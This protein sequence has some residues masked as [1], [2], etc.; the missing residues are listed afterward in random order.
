MRPGPWL[1]ATWVALGVGCESKPKAPPKEVRVA[2][3]APSPPPPPAKL[4]VA[5]VWGGAVPA[6]DPR[7]NATDGYRHSPADYGEPDWD[8]VRMHAL[9]HVSLAGRDRARARAAASDFDAC[10]ERYRATESILRGAKLANPAVTPVRDVLADGLARD[11]ALCDALHREMPPVVPATGGLEMYRAR[12]LGLYVRAE[13][14]QDVRRAASTLSGELG[15]AAA[16]SGTLPWEAPAGERDSAKLALALAEAWVDTVDPIAITEPWG[17]WSVKERPRQIAALRDAVAAAASGNTKRLHVFPATLLEPEVPAWTVDEFALTPVADAAYDMLGFAAP[18]VVPRL[19]VGAADDP[20]WRA[21]LESKLR[22]YAQMRSGEVPRAV[23]SAVAD[24]SDAEAGSRY[25]NIIGFQDAAIRQLARGGHYREAREVLKAQ[26]PL[27]GLDWYMP[28][29]GAV[30]LAIDG[31]L[32]VLSGDP[33]G[34]KR[35]AA[36]IEE[37]RAFL[38]FIDVRDRVD[39]AAAAK[40]AREAAREAA[41]HR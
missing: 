7:A 24:L 33:Q 30:L 28:D 2:E 10:A 29:R 32:A 37:S 14:G 41:R 31:R 19:T 40:A 38:D 18:H 22:V 35:L 4:P 3:K 20:E 25:F 23:K 17:A 5:A 1:L 11:A 15:R 6:D 36:S 27:R 39:A 16:R 21:W 12:F 34:E 26:S 8:H 9:V 13:K